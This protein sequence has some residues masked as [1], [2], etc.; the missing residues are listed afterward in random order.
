M[1]NSYRIFTVSPGSTSTKLAI[2]NN[3][4]EEI[5]V[6]VV[7]SAEKLSEFP[8]ISNQLDYR[9][10]A[11]E[12]ELTAAGIS[13]EGCDAF[14]AYSGSLVST[15]GGTYT[16]NDKM[17]HHS[18]ICY[19]V[20]HPAALGAQI[21]HHFSEKY[22]APAFVVDPPDTD[23]LC[24]VARITGLKGIYREARVHALNQK[25]TARR[26]A[27]KLGKSYEDVNVIVAHM[28]GGISV[29]AHKNG[30]M[31]DS[32]DCVNGSG[33]MSPNRPGSIPVNS[34]VDL[35]FSGKYT[36][37]ELRT[38]LMKSSGLLDHIG[39]D[40]GREA[41]S[42]IESGDKYAEIVYDGMIYQIAKEIA[43]MAVALGGKA[44]AIG[45]TGGMSKGKYLTD[46]ITELTGW[47]AP[48]VVFGGDFEMEALN[49]G[50]IRVLSG[51][52][53]AKEYTGVPVWNG[54]EC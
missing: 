47:I 34:V 35:C 33:P 13:L 53:Q 22:S 43:C 52:E 28:G 9:I 39:T 51:E 32:N 50:A 10:E 27:A 14:A 7:H 38:H 15:L 45:L 6:N 2:F 42:R 54:F 37:K 48:V 26:L 17:L 20:R 12:T 29:A 44:D 18:R 24:D 21:I 36:E 40:D 16:V 30:L 23:E 25:E 46:K 19:T 41:V 1:A 49:N 4:Q 3:G 8:E 31:V 5:S 11:I